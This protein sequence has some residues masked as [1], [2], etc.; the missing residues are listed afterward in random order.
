LRT[1]GVPA[2]Y[3]TGFLPGEYND[4]A[5]DYI[6]RASDAHSWVEVYFPG[7]G[8]ITF[9]PT[10]PGSGHSN[11]MFARLGMYWDWFQFNWNEWVINYDFSHQ[12]TLGR[13]IHQS[14]RAWS[15]RI[16]QYYQAKRRTV[17]DFMKLWQARLSS[18]PYSLPGALVF[19]LILLIYFRGRAMGGFVAVRWKLRAQR[20]GKLP[21]ELAAFEYRQMLHLLERRGWRKPASLTPLEFAASIPAPEF[22]IPVTELTEIYQSARFG[23]HPADARRVTWLLNTLKQLRIKRSR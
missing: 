10:P 12:L 19:L 14:S 17:L 16:S 6:V 1:L 23:T 20:E 9:D 5:Q 21:A 3:A 2:R 4:L 13:N 8:W 18:S 11:G 22:A 15:D 7:Y